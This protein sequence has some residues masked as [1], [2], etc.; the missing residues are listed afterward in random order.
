[1]LLRYLSLLLVLGVGGFAFEASNYVSYG[2]GPGGVSVSVGRREQV[3]R[4][5]WDLDARIF[6]GTETNYVQGSAS[7]MVFYGIGYSGLGPALGYNHDPEAW[8]KKKFYG[9]LAPELTQGVMLGDKS[10]IELRVLGP[11]YHSSGTHRIVPI[12]SISYGYRF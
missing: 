12:G 11:A 7:A 3:E 2:V 9:S 6:A 4:L 10:F 1:M 8:G 5:G